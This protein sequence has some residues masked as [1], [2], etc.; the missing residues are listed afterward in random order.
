MY[1]RILRSEDGLWEKYVRLQKEVK[2]LVTE[3]KLQIRN[4]VVHK[5]KSDYERNKKE[6]WAFVGRRTNGKKGIVALRN[7]AGVSVT[8]TKGK[9]EVLKT[10]YRHLNSCSVDSAFDDSWK[11]ELDE[12]VSECS[13][14]SNS[15]LDREIER[16]KIAVCVRKLKNNKTGG[17]DGLVG[18]L[19]Y[20]RS[21]MI[22]LLQQLFAV[23]WRD[24]SGGKA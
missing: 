23:V 7:S 4:E 24:R 11:E 13:S 18:E 12:Q 14:V 6:F 9:L 10:H 8:S 3:K 1:K 17:S 19:K 5:A 20:G 16:E 2:Q 15:V 21:G 22:D